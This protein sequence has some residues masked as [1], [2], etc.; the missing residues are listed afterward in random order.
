MEE[1]TYILACVSAALVSAVWLLKTWRHN[2]QLNPIPAVG[3]SGIWGYYTGGLRYMLHAPEMVQEGCTL[4]PGKAFRVPRLFR[5]DF[6]VSGK[7][8]I[9]EV[10]SAPESILSALEGNKDSLKVD[11]TIGPEILNHAYHIDV[12]RTTLTRNL[13][14]CFPDIRD[15]ISCAFDDVLALDGAEWKSVPAL[16]TIMSVVARST[17]RLFVGLP[18]CRNDDYLKLMVRYTIDVV[19]MAQVIN[20]MPAPLQPIL[21]PFISPRSRGIRKGTTHLGPLIEHRIAQEKAFGRDWPGKPNDFISWLLDSAQ[22]SERTVPD[23]VVRILTT[24]MAAIHTTSSVFTHVLFDLTS[25]PEYMPA[26]RE[27]AERVVQELGW[28]KTA[29]G[30]MYR[31][32][33]FLRESQRMHDNGPVTMTRKVMDP[34]GF[35]FSD[36]TVVPAGSFINATSR[37]EHFSP[38]NYED[39]DDFDGFRFSKLREEREQNEGQAVFNKHMVTTSVE[40]LSFGH[41]THVCPGRFLAAMQLKAMLAH[42]VINYDVRSAT[43]GVRP[44]D[45]VFGI[46]AVPNRK[47]KIGFRKRL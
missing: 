8:L 37:V 32:D 27:E 46:V 3:A 42:I 36:G 44:P 15:E 18:I 43:D 11:I 34:A 33:S 40:H 41:R 14:K 21:G 5:W 29:L 30:R 31:L 38:A 10:A 4:Y 35:T 45:D 24:N 47:A 19:I 39:P 26:L 13:A 1:P 6:I 12:L 28:T 20:L 2:R 23:I 9:D 7:T 25:H 16:S 22:G 17:N